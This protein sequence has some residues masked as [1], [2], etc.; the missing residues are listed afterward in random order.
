M[1]N[2]K[3]L[4]SLLDCL[5]LDKNKPE[6]VVFYLQILAWAKL[7]A[8]DSLKQELSFNPQF[9]SDNFEKVKAIFNDIYKNNSFLKNALAFKLSDINIDND[10]VKK[11]LI[12]VEDLSKNGIINNFR[13]SNEILYKILN[14]DK[15]YTGIF[16]IP[17]ELCDLMINLLGDITK[18]E[19]YCPYDNYCDFS[20]KIY[21]KGGLPY[22][23]I[24]STNLIPELINILN[25]SDITIAHSDP[26]LNPSYVKE[27]KL[28]Q[29]DLAMSCP[30]IGLKYDSEVVKKDWFNRFSHINRNGDVYALSHILSQTKSRIV[31]IVAHSMLFSSTTEVFRETILKENQIEAVIALP[32]AIFPYTSFQ[33]SILIFDLHK[34]K[35]T[36]RFVDGSDEQFFIR[37]HHQSQLVNWQSLLETYLYGEDESLVVDIDI[38]TIL[39]NHSILE[40]SKYILP[41]E[42]KKV[43]QLLIDQKTVKLSEI[44][45][46]ISPLQI[47]YLKRA[48][49]ES[50]IKAWEITASN[51]PEYGYLL[52]PEKEVETIYSKKDNQHFLQPNDVVFIYKGS[53][54]KVGIIPEDVP[55]KGEG[56]WVVNQSCLILRPN[57]KIN[58][59]VLFMYLNSEV[60]QTLVKRIIS[61][62]T[63]PLIQLKLLKELEIMMPNQQ[64][65]Q[66]IISTFDQMVTIQSQIQNLFQE[67]ENLKRQHWAISP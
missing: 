64:E 19:I 29:F 25:N 31:V 16:F 24:L 3:I 63:I 7:S 50:K 42:Q 18:K 60:G 36:V 17:S 6:Y 57:K 32:S 47:S 65:S 41:P 26:I 45:T 48:D 30:P 12:L 2:E 51:F 38:E 40:V 23:E 39:N 53:V 46:I 33:S 55:P 27:G 59:K 22:I 44:V 56:G 9:L 67:Q 14:S 61:G 37:S 62:A 8:S 21:E 35:K 10:S 34:T 20:L 4:S 52:K 15:N 66:K 43:T 54:G 58:A 11:L 13:I 1:D 28:K 49:K 5:P